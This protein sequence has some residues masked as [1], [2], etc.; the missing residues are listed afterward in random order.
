MERDSLI[1]RHWHALAGTWVAKGNTYGSHYF[2]KPGDPCAPHNFSSGDP[3]PRGTP[4]SW[5]EHSELCR[6]LGE[7]CPPLPGLSSKS[8]LPSPGVIVA[9]LRSWW[10]TK[11]VSG[12]IQDVPWVAN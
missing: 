5:G 3:I 7:V 10:N 11:E 9:P 6:G 2:Y 8:I 4:T 1:P 12:D